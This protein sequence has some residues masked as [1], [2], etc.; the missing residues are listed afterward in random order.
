M[1]ALDRKLWRDL[2]QMK[3]QAAAIALVVTCGVATFVMFLS[4]LDALRATQESFYR[5]YR[6]ADVFVTL[7]RGPEA[8]QQRIQDIPGVS[9]VQ[10]R[11]KAQVRLVIPDF[12]EPV[13]ALMVSVPESDSVGLN[14]LYLREGRMPLSGR[15]DEVVVSVPFVQ[16]HAMQLGARFYAILNGRR[17]ELTLVGTALSPEFVQQM[18][19]GSAFPDY[20]R[21]GVMWMGRRALGQ[22]YDMHGAFND[23]TL[24]LSPGADVQSVIDHVDELLNPYGGQGAYTRKDQ[25]SHRFL[26]QELQ[27]LGV[28]ASLFPVIFMGIAAFLLN[29][30]IGRLITM[31]REQIATLKAFG[32]GNL[33]V[34]W[35]YLKMVAVIVLAGGLS[36]IA[37]GVYLGKALAGIYME[38]YHFPYLRFAL[39]PETLI[40]AVLASLAAAAAGTVFAVWR[41]ASLKPA[42]AMRPEPPARY[43][44]TW[45]EKLGVK[46]WLTQPARMIVRHIQRQRIKSALSVFGVA[47]AGGIILTSLFQRDTVSYMVDIQFGMAQRQD[48]LVTFTEPTAYRARFDLSGLPEVQHVEVFRAVPVRLRHGARHYRTNI[49]GVEPNGDMQR[50]LDANLHPVDLP[51]DGLLLTDFLAT[52][53]DVRV[54]DRVIV[55]VLEQNR[56]VREAVVVGLV[57]EYLGVS[58]YM[59]LHALNRFMHEGPTLSGAYLK[60]DRDRLDTLYAQ[61][62]EMPRVASITERM[63]EIRNLH[64]VMQETMLFFTYIAAVFSVIIAFGVIY[65][66]ARIALAERGRELAS[67]RVMGFTRGEIAYILLG[68]LGILTLLAIPVGLW[69]GRLMC[70]YIAHNMQNDLFRVPVV[71]VPQTYAFSMAVVLLSA[72]LSGLAV[73][74]RL[75][76][77]DLIGVLKAA[78]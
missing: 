33:E 19:P 3:S 55:E 11:V 63:Q 20:K 17:Q 77:L 34:L 8:M 68:E 70:Y 67:L 75:D 56:P 66:S 25:L 5:E 14:S 43:R 4:T 30:V 62:K 53:L 13:T 26:D 54:G 69:L 15:P 78:E 38:F 52:L 39:H 60:V 41:A 24:S 72:L 10:S 46:R 44:E 73:R 35:H 1:N 61:L 64:R 42:Q 50:L 57:K 21:Y 71:L 12:P 36:G 27:Q 6:F 7:K 49:Q 76:Q 16:A 47:L 51:P 2:G 40:E 48:L 28:L 58:G 32:Y 9:Q 29:V 74:R 37:L 31:Q 23:L 59:D 65:N 22:A 45:L 18:R